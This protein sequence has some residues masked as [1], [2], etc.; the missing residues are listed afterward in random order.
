MT[1]LFNIYEDSLN[2]LMNKGSKI[3]DGFSSLNDGMIIFIKNRKKK[4]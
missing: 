3:T 2:I 4:L 1:E